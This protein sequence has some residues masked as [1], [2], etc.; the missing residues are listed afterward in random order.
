M[1]ALVLSDIAPGGT[2]AALD[3][4]GHIH[5]A[6]YDGGGEI[7]DSTARYVELAGP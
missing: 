7:H 5:L 6:M 3:A 1:T 4:T 2:T